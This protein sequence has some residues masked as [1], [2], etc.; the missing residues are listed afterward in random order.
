MSF[1]SHVGENS[2]VYSANRSTG[3]LGTCL[4]VLGLVV[5]LKAMLTPQLVVAVLI[6][7][8]LLAACARR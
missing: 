8:E 5:P 1:V 2:L 7:G 3:L 4:Y 6:T